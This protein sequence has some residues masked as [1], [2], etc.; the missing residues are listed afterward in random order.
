[1]YSLFKKELIQFLGSLTGYLA[2][3]V[4]LLVS[5]LFLWVFPGNYNI[6]ESGYAS[7]EPFFQLAPWLYLFLIP[8]I[9]M[10]LFA[11]EKK[12]GTLELLLTRPLTDLRLVA[13]KFL[14]SLVLVGFSLLPTLLY[15]FSVYR[16][17]NPVGNI[18]VGSTWGAFT[19]LFFLAAL[20]ISIGLF[21]S[22]L[23]DSQIV[24]FILAMLSAFLF[25][26]GFEFIAGSGVPYFLVKLFSWF[27]INDHYLSLSR[28]VIDGRDLL[29]FT[30]M[31]AF[32]LAL[33]M[34]LLRRSR[35]SLARAGKWIAGL[36]TCLLLLILVSENIRFQIDLTADKRYT[37]SSVSKRVAHSIDEPVTVELFLEGELPPGFRK[38]QQAITAKVREL[39]RYSGKPMRIRVTDPYTAVPLARRDEFIEELS[40]NGI[41]PTDLHRKTSKGTE[42]TLIFPGALVTQGDR[43]VSVNFLKNT[44]GI[45]HEINLNHSVE[46][47]EYELVSALMRISEK[48]KPLLVFLQGHGEL[49]PYQ[50]E[51]LGRELSSS[52]RV[53]FADTEGLRGR[54]TVPGVLVIAAPTQ[55]FSEA[56]KLVIDQLLMKGSRILWAVDPVEV[57]LD[58]LSQGFMTMAFPRDL[59]LGDQLFHYGVRINSDLVQDVNCAQILVNTSL[60]AEK[61]VFTPQ[62]W[63]YSPLLTPSPDHPVT[64]NV[65]LLYAEFVSSIDTLSDPLRRRAT[66][67]LGTSPYGRVV[68]TPAGVSLESINR[69]PARELFNRSHIPAGVLLEGKFQ[70]VFSNRMVAHLGINPASLVEESPETRMMVFSDGSLMANK[71]RMVPGEK[72]QILPLGYD[73]V[74]RQIF[75]N[76]EFFTRAIKYLDDKNGVM[77]LLNTSVKLRLLDKVRLR[78]RGKHWTWVNTALPVLFILLFGVIYRQVRKRK[79][80]SDKS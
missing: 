69:P 26:L 40:A 59:N 23:T 12:S 11:E 7:L 71:V 48:E 44:P 45:N 50:V 5:G 73:R 25:F 61:P 41:R 60:S 66:V 14:A 56:D 67:I 78:E 31:T 34:L 19:G 47:V 51:D 32:F 74:S 58:S 8:A 17:G 43:R 36:L 9:T 62:S 24:A 42:T 1:M 57:S 18:D 22:V 65:N 30:G 33:T 79:Y 80:S 39:D 4:F 55:P 27:S 15:F 13:A 77:Q 68:R 37:L 64:K 63:Y 72:P 29:Y 2:V 54:D 52:F 70:S 49:D 6:P 35:N 75:G 38:L 21:A 76:K 10:R 3:V 16:L 20:Y 28:G 46:S 53:E